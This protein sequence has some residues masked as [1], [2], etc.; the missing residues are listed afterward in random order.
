M[1]FKRFTEEGYCCEASGPEASK[2]S[3]SLIC[4]ERGFWT[5][6]YL[7]HGIVVG[8]RLLCAGR[9]QILNSLSSMWFSILTDGVFKFLS[10]F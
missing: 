9:T 6:F 2:C 10:N 5:K 1:S 8:A 3:S 7:A 4:A